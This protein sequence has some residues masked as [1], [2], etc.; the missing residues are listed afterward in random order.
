MQSRANEEQALRASE[1]LRELSE[2]E[3]DLEQRENT[4]AKKSKDL[5]KTVN[6]MIA[7]REA[8]QRG[9]G[10]KNAPVVHHRGEDE[11]SY[12]NF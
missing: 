11:F 8:R 10:L 3:K 5:N 12:L 7:T 9:D 2:R 6:E 4:L 1:R